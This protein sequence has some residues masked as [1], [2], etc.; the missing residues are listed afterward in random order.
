MTETQQEQ[1][2]I[3]PAFQTFEWNIPAANHDGGRL[4]LSIKQDDHL[5][6]IGPNG[7]GKSALIQHFVSKA[8]QTCSIRRISA[9]R[10]TW[11][12]SGAIE[13]TP[14]ARED[15][16][17]TISGQ[18]PQYSSRY[19]DDYAAKRLS[20]VLFDLVASENERARTI[21]AHI[22]NKE[23]A[24]AETAAAKS[25][26]P[27]KRI[28]ELLLTGNFTVQIQASSGEEILARHTEGEPFS[29]AKLSDGERNAIILAANVLTVRQGTILLIDEPE[30]HLHRSIMEPFLAA[31]FECRPDCAFV[32]S[33]HEL[34]LAATSE[35]CRV[36]LPRSCQWEGETPSGWNIDL[37]EGSTDL[38][39]DLKEAILGSRQTIVFIEGEVESLDLPLYS[40]LLPETTL[41]PKGSCD[42]VC[43]AV[44][45]LRDA[46]SIHWIRAFGLIDHDDRTATDISD[47]EAKGVYALSVHSAEALYYSEP[48]LEAIANRQAE[49]L[50]KEEA[51]LLEEAKSAALAS[52]SDEATKRRMCAR[53]CERRVLNI[54][55]AARPNWKTIQ[56][57]SDIDL[58]VAVQEPFNEELGKYQAA[59][60][61]GDLNSLTNRYP[62]RETSALAGIAT[63]L[64]FPSRTLYEQA[65]LVAIDKDETLRT[66]LRALIDP[67][68]SMIIDN[69]ATESGEAAA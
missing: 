52:L 44:L 20:S 19:M 8:G 66:T 54:L 31:L 59:T 27:F 1:E 65:V 47:L 18:E 51:V 11:L 50:G 3:E 25:V 24:Q 10:Q 39:P 48:V 58:T 17:T 5:F 34:S 23:T 13:I 29:I 14:K 9:H 42:E 21:A 53:R 56:N 38:P 12:K 67:L 68:A 55:D 63:A 61:A 43:R 64:K 36:L 6:I 26:S 32:V 57:G 22:D 28:N 37:L 62:I 33:T 41:V 46:E 69:A 7:S 35:S 40:I 30:R 49:T 45:G 16:E 60:D 15:L 4:Q 2:E